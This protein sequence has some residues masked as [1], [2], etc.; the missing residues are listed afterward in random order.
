M[1]PVTGSAADAESGAI[2][3]TWFPELASRMTN[4]RPFFGDTQLLLHLRT[5]YRNNEASPDT[6]QEAWAGGGWLAY[7]S[8]WLADVF[9]IGATGYLS[10]PLYAPDDRDGTLLLEPGQDPIAILGEAWAK[11]RYGDH[12]LTGYRQRINSGTSTRKTTA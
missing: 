7:R 6:F 8:G 5:F 3:P 1:A 11:F 9:S 12:V 10:L 4:A 2:L